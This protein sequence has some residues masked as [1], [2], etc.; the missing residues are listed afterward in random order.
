MRKIFVK[1][2]MFILLSITIVNMRTIISD[3]ATMTTDPTDFYWSTSLGNQGAGVIDY[4][5]EI[6]WCSRANLAST[7][8][9]RYDNTGW[10]VQIS[11]TKGDSTYYYVSDTVCLIAEENVSGYGYYL[12]KINRDILIDGVEDAGYSSTSFFSTTVTVELDGHVRIINASGSAVAGGYSLRT[13]SGLNYLLEKMEYY[14]FTEASINTIMTELRN[15]ILTI[16]GS[17]I[18][19]EYTISYNANGGSGAPSSQIKYY[20]ISTTLSNTKP[21]RTGYTFKSWN[22]NASGTGTTYNPGSTLSANQ[23][24]TLYA[25]WEKNITYYT[26]DLNASINSGS[27]V[28]SFS[29]YGT[30][31][32]YLNGT[33]VANDVS[34]YYNSSIAEGTTYLINDIKVSTGYSNS[35]SSSYSGSMTK[36]TSVVLGFKKIN[37]YILDLNASINSGSTVGS[38]SGYGTVD[39]Y[40]NGTKVANDV[41]DYYNIS[42]VE[43][44]TY[45]I[46]DIKVSTGYSNSGS[47]SYSGSMTKNTSVVLGF[48]NITYT[49]SYQSNTSDSVSNMPGSQTKIHGSSLVLSSS[50]PTRSGYT[51][52][53][54]NTDASGNGTAYNPE[55]TLSANQT[56]TLYAIWDKNP[57]LVVEDVY[58]YLVDELDE[59]RLLENVIA[60][61]EEDGDISE[62]VIVLNLNDVKEKLLEYREVAYTQEQEITIELQYS[63]TDSAGA[64]ITKTS[65]LHVYVFV[66][67]INENNVEGY[68]RFI[69]SD[70]LDTLEEKSVWREE[71]MGSYLKSVLESLY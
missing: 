50:K 10:W 67:D 45:L 49:I 18:L 15:K 62:K 25:I 11:N 65:V 39:V 28:G 12:Y 33:K 34:D 16:A 41:S 71:E 35:G 22:T 56:L 9:Y 8:T 68:V 46:N 23:A 19:L 7:A 66:E 30:A 24:L 48:K 40:L 20:N 4:N 37:Y 54:W 26:L 13:E 5:G 44:T 57:S 14:S 60:E 17:D 27:T 32:V 63:I 31:D 58:M 43:G 52:L 53:E 21:T 42:V 61:D 69:S 47:S 51:F 6:Y 38:F 1:G 70:Y 29:G 3:A 2:M 64:K 59:E 55:G 36:N